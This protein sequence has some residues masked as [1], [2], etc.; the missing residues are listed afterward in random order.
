M[1][2]MA[3]RGEALVGFMYCD[4][5]AIVRGRLIPARDLDRRL[6]SGLGWVPANQSI[7]AFGDLA[8]PNPFGSVG[9]L[10]ILP[11]PQTHVH[12]DLW[13][14]AAPLDFLL[15]TAVELDGTPWDCCPRAFASRLAARPRGGV[16]P[17]PRRELRARVPARRRRAA[18]AAVLARVV[19]P[20]GAVRL[21]R[22]GGAA[23]G[24]RRRR[25]VPAGVRPAPVRGA[26]PA[27]GGHRGGRPQRDREGGR[28]RGR[29]AA[30]P[31][32]DVHAAAVAGRDRQRRA[33]PPEPA[34]RRRRAARTT[35]TGRAG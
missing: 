12:V 31:A 5:A 10:R 28:A 26:V 21:A 29:A 2:P 8:E 23:R 6:A 17:A 9:D 20:R 24:R 33:R 35:P 11:D 19:P 18:G 1:A 15:C 32:G 30:R 34:G 25:H 4:L 27:G 14:D 3:P 16:R 7:T 13:D 22:R